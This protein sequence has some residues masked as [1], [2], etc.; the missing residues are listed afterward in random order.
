M[1]R[2]AQRSVRGG[3]PP[4]AAALNQMVN[5]VIAAGN[6][7]EVTYATDVDALDFAPGDHVSEPSGSISTAYVQFDLN[8]LTVTMAP[9]I[10]GDTDLNYA[11][12]APGIL[13]PD[14]IPY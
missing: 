7:A 8:V 5:A 12:A 6:E 14:T 11:G 9:D 10:I 2:W 1:G 13:T 3:G 4:T